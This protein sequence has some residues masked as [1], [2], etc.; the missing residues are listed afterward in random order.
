MTSNFH[1]L[2]R[3][4]GTV[5]ARA[6]NGRTARTQSPARKLQRRKSQIRNKDRRFGFGSWELGFLSIVRPDVACPSTPAPV[7]FGAAGRSGAR[8]GCRP[9]AR[10]ASKGE[11][12]VP[13]GA[14]RCCPS[15]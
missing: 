2:V 7:Y 6:E 15:T 5:C 1:S 10:G 14:S 12:N 8:V 3:R 13:R 11:G 4:G 9:E